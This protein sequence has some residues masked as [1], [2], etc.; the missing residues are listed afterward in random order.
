M[1]ISELLREGAERRH[2]Y[3]AGGVAVGIVTDINDPEKMGRMKV[4]LI[5]RDTSEYETDFIRAVTIMSGNKWGTYFMPEV[6]DEVLV[7]FAEGDMNRPYVIG[8]LWNNNNQPP[9]NI[10]DSKNDIRKIKTRS[11]FWNGF[12]LLFLILKSHGLPGFFTNPF[13]FFFNDMLKG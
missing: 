2:S 4:K 9:E 10:Q 7:A 12:S 11:G 3:F 6:G 8:A 5:N 1:S 13:C